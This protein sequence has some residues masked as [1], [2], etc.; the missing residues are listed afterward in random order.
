ME[1]PI[2]LAV[3]VGGLYFILWVAFQILREWWKMKHDQPRIVEYAE[4]PAPKRRMYKGKA[5]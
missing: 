3:A 5:L 2:I 4:R 1:M